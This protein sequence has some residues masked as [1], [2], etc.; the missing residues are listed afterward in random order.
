MQFV[1]IPFLKTKERLVRS[2]LLFLLQS[3]RVTVKHV[4]KIR[5]GRICHTFG[6][7]SYTYMA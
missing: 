7:Y 5:L 1:C 4:L 6:I 3:V 2:L